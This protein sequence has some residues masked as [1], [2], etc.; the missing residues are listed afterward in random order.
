MVSLANFKKLQSYSF[1]LIM[2]TAAFVSSCSGDSEILANW[3]NGKITRKNFRDIIGLYR[4]KEDMS[5]ISVK[6][7]EKALQNFAMMQITADLARKEQMDKSPDYELATTFTDKTAALASLNKML[8]EKK[9]DL[10]LT[11]WDMQILFLSS[12]QNKPDVADRKEEA[13]ELTTK[14]NSGLSDREIEIII[15]DKSENK[16]YAMI[17]GYLDPHCVSCGQN[18]ISFLT[19]PL[20]NAEMGKFVNIRNDRGHWIIRKIKEHRT[21]EDDLEDLFVSYQTKITDVMKKN[22]QETI[23]DKTRLQQS[24]KRIPDSEKIEKMAKEQAQA[25]IHRVSESEN[26]ELIDSLKKEAGL[27]IFEVAIPGKTDKSKLKN[28]TVLFKTNKMEYTYGQ[29]VSPLL[30]ANKDVDLNQVLR[31]LHNVIIPY[32]VMSRHPDMEKAK[33]SDLYDFI[34]KMR[35]DDALS[36]LYLIKHQPTPEV[37]DEDIRQWFELRKNNEFN[38]KTF[39]SVKDNIK[40]RLT[41]TKGQ[42]AF[43]SYQSKLI[44]EHK[45]VVNSKL[46]KPGEI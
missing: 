38:G 45:L 27:E 34:L 8:R 16:R 2:A 15:R 43:N 25:Q 44:S 3:D 1:I 41:Q 39:A 40:K 19:D 30:Q 9:R 21:D 36:R 10:D 35:N 13:D 12:P 5:K 32:E 26:R 29:L 14:L 42:E 28:D 24:L 11:M 22:L 7:Q 33:K 37:T 46:L 6:E 4:S 17:G 18:P 23:K 31:V 20:K